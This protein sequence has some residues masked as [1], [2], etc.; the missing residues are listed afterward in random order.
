[1]AVG[2]NICARTVYAKELDLVDDAR[3]DAVADWVGEPLLDRRG[4]R[5]LEAMGLVVR[6]RP[7]EPEHVAIEVRHGVEPQRAALGEHDAGDDFTRLAAL[8]AGQ[9]L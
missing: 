1:M 2:T 7:V 6:A 8:Q 5:V 4:E 9:H 3:A